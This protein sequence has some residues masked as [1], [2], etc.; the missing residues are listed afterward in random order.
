MEETLVTTA[1]DLSGRSYLVFQAEFPTPKIGEFDSELVDDFWQA[2]A[3]NALCN[4]HV[5]RAPRPQQPPHRRSDLQGHGPGAAHGRRTRPPHHR[6]AQHEGDAERVSGSEAAP[7][8]NAAKMPKAAK[9]NAGLIVRARIC[10]VARWRLCQGYANWLNSGVFSYGRTS[11]LTA[12]LRS[13]VAFGLE[14][15]DEQQVD[16]LDD[17][18][19][20]GYANRAAGTADCQ[21]LRMFDRERATV[22][23]KYVERLKRPS[24]MKVTNLIGGHIDRIRRIRVQI[25]ITTW[26]FALARC[27]SRPGGCGRPWLILGRSFD[28]AA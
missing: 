19:V 27:Q 2:V 21:A 6:R 15:G 18:F 14:A 25:K 22:R 7:N 28:F 24:L 20:D 16:G 13:P 4:L 9:A 26:K 5:M 23:Q 10:G 11:R 1:I 12:A 17:V 3:A 8:S